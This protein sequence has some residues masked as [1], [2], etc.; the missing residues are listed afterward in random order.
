VDTV[1]RPSRGEAQA[2]ADERYA[3]MYHA[4]PD[5]VASG[6]VRCAHCK[7]RHETVAE[8]RW[9]SDLA[10]EAKAEALADAEADRAY[11]RDREAIAERGTWMGVETAEEREAEADAQAAEEERKRQAESDWSWDYQKRWG[12][13]ENE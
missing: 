2:E 10:A 5:T 12:R 13:A 9:C 11:A 3:E 6:G 8:V 4:G 1:D 7:A